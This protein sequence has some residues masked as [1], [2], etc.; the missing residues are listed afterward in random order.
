MGSRVRERE[1]ARETKIKKKDMEDRTGDG[2]A[3]R[4]GEGKERQQRP[5]SSGY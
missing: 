4:S 1:G 2:R 5:D 3:L